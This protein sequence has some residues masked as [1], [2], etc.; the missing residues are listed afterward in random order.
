MISIIYSNFWE[1]HKSY[2]DV[3]YDQVKLKVKCFDFIESTV[4]KP[5]EFAIRKEDEFDPESEEVMLFTYN[6]MK[7]ADFKFYDEL[8]EF[9]WRNDLY[10]SVYDHE[11]K[12]RKG[13]WH[14]EDSKWIKQK[15]MEFLDY[16]FE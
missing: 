8:H 16:L 5:D 15:D 11:L 6:S 9:S 2:V 3:R 12:M 14:D 7:V 4:G 10:V 13:F 1:W